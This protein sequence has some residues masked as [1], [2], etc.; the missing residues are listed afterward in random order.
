MLSGVLGVILVGGLLTWL[1]LRGGAKPRTSHTEVLQSTLPMTSDAPTKLADEAYDDSPTVV[2]EPLKLAADWKRT[3]VAVARE[4][5]ETYPED[6]ISYALLGSAFF[7]I[8]QSEE[9]VANLRRCIELDPRQTEAY[10]IMARVAY[11]K[12]ELEEAIRLCEQGLMYNKEDLSMLN[13]LGQALLDLGRAGAA[14]RVLEQTLQLPNRT[15][16]SFYL[17]G[18]AYLQSDDYTRAM[19]SFQGAIGLVPDHTQ[20]FFGLFTA[21]SRLGQVETAKMHREQFLKLET[22]DRQ[23]LTESSVQEDTLSG[24]PL[25]RQ[26]VARTLLGAGQIYSL[27]DRT[28]KAEEL[29]F[30]AAAIDPDNAATR[31]ALEALLVR[32]DAVAEAVKIFEKFAVDQPESSLN[33]LFLGRLHDR[34][35]H[36]NESERAYRKVQELTPEMPEG[37]RAL[38]EL[39]FRS[40]RKHVEARFLARRLLELEPDSGPNYYLLAFASIKNNDRNGAVEAME[41]AVTLSP[42]NKRFQEFLRQ[43]QKAP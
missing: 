43:L 30:M 19:E 15:S 18:Q 26:T 21:S 14:I 36:F 28:G 1:V 42:G 20:A 25:V 7:N 22:I 35:R 16:E 17:L 10:E 41:K 12:G 40:D 27:H 11:D 2:P 9:A 39:Y 37:Y 32:R 38:I 3:A 23:A 8:G 34:L 4:V 5:V 6:A 33:Y 24:L 31:A 29:F 13:R